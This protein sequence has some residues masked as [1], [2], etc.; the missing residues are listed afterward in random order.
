MKLKFRRAFTLVELLVVIGI[1]AL[2]IS[3]LLPALSR[4]K[5]AAARTACL[6][7]HKQILTAVHMYAGDNKGF[8]PFCNWRSYDNTFTGF[9]YKGVIA[10][11]STNAQVVQQLKQGSLFQY[12]KSEKI[13]RCPFDTEPPGSVGNN[14]VGTVH[15]IS[16]YSMNGA[17]NNFCNPMKWTRLTQYKAGEILIWEIDEKGDSGYWHDAA[18]FPWEGITKRHGGRNSGANAGAIVG[19]FGGHAEWITVG[20]FNKEANVAGGVRS[21]LWCVP[22]AISPGGGH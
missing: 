4:A 13:Y 21:R 3:I 12:L 20:E 6:S 14:A 10:G 7:N 18:N 15:H 19:C 9:C 17:V 11:G 22:M 8:L 2:L 1:I 16:S 5:E